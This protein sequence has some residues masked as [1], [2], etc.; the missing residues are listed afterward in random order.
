MGTG[1]PFPGAKARPERDAD[2]SPPFSVEVVNDKELYIL[3]L[4]APP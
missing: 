4:P 3:F 2:L 1:G